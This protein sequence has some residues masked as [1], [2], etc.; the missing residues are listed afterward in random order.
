MLYL[1]CGLLA[2]ALVALDQWVKWWIVG[3]FAIGETA[4]LIPHVLGLTH[5]HNTGAAWSV[6]NQHTWLLSVVSAVVILLLLLVLVSR[7]ISHPVGV[8]TLTLVLA[9]A[10]GNLIDRVRLGYVVDMF[11]TLFVDFPIFNVADICVVCGG[12]AF[13]FYFV[14]CSEK[15]EKKP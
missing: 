11:Q 7:K 12:I 2:V 6:L 9:G 4:P 3:H 15:W 1:F 5:V 13:C 10:V 8:F 14:L